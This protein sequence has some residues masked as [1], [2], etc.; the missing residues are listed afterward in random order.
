MRA[1]ANNVINKLV[2]KRSTDDGTH[3]TLESPMAKS[4]ENF[5]ETPLLV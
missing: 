2:V 3:W 5:N 1:T 4:R